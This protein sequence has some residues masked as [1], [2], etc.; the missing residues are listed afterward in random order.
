MSRKPG[1]I[2][3]DTEAFEKEYI[4]FVATVAS[5]GYP[6]PTAMEPRIGTIPSP[7]GRGSLHI[8][9]CC[10]T[11]RAIVRANIKYIKEVETLTYKG[12]PTI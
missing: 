12:F 7:S 8:W 9:R 1:A 4:K 10:E 3:R 5:S 2:H 11:A 6:G